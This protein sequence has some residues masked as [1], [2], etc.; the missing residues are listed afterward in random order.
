MAL[1]EETYFV[2][3]VTYNAS[4]KEYFVGVD[5][6]KLED[7]GDFVL[8][9]GGINS[10]L[11]DI[12]IIPWAIF[13]KIL[14]KGEPINTYKPPKEYFQYKSTNQHFVEFFQFDGFLIKYE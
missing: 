1:C 8:I 14:E 5:P 9:C 7:R 10:T 3:T 13:F 6:K 11:R 4:R 12:F 2:K